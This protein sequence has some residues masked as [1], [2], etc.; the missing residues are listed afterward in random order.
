MC[1]REALAQLRRRGPDGG[2]WL[3]GRHIAAA[4]H[5]GSGQVLRRRVVVAEA[6]G[7]R[8]RV[9][10]GQE[11]LAGDEG[12]PVLLLREPGSTRSAPHPQRAAHTGTRP[13]R[14]PDGPYPPAPVCSLKVPGPAEQP[15]SL[16]GVS[17]IRAEYVH[18]VNLQ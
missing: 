7:Q 14:L 8:Y 13:R 18:R 10:N 16:I 2:T 5:R 15:S 12:D 17:I 1:L 9:I 6:A 3:N 11:A 4:G